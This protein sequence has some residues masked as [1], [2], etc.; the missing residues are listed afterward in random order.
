M[1]QIGTA[2]SAERDVTQ[3]RETVASSSDNGSAE[4]GERRI[5]R[6]IDTTGSRLGSRRV[7]MT[8]SEWRE[9]ERQN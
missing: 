6:Q 8:R 3:P 7:C 9:F 2:G 4:A 1:A 5:C